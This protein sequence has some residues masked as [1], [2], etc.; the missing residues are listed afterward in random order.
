MNATELIQ[1]HFDQIHESIGQVFTLD[2]IQRGIFYFKSDLGR[3]VI[4]HLGE[5]IQGKDEIKKPLTIT[6]SAK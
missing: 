1:A 2:S 5:W 4:V 6:R 3:D